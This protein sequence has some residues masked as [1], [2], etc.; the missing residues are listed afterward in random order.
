M[1]DEGASATT[2]PP[3]TLARR[4]GRDGVV[5]VHGAV[6]G[7]ELMTAGTGNDARWRG[8]VA[9]GI[10]VGGAGAVLVGLV[11]AYVRDLGQIPTLASLLGI[12]VLL[13]M[14]A[15]AVRSAVVAS[16]RFRPPADPHT[17]RLTWGLWTFALS[18][19]TGGF[20]W[21]QVAND[22]D[23]GVPTLPLPHVAGGATL[24][25]FGALLIAVTGQRARRA[26]SE[27]AA[28][29]AGTRPQPRLAAIALSA[30]AALLA[31]GS[32]AVAA[33]AV[34]RAPV[35]ATTT[36]ASDASPF[37]GRPEEVL[38]NWRPPGER[39]LISDQIHGT[40]TGVAVG[41]PDRVVALDGATGEEAWSYRRSG[42]SLHALSA[43]LS[44]RSLAAV[45]DSGNHDDSHRRLVTFDAATGRVGTDRVVDRMERPLL[46]DDAVI[47]REDRSLI[48]MSL[49]DGHRMWT[50][51]LPED[52]EFV[53][54]SGEMHATATV[55]VAGGLCGDNW[56]SGAV[57]TV[58]AIDAGT[59]H[60][61][62]RFV[63][64]DDHNTATLET[65]EDGAYALFS[66]GWES[67]PVGNVLIDVATG[68]AVPDVANVAAMPSLMV[69]QG[70]YAA[71][72][73][74]VDGDASTY[75][76][77]GFDGTTRA[78]VE[79]SCAEGQGWDATATVDALVEICR[80]A[81]AAPVTIAVTPWDRPGDAYQFTDPDVVV[82][83]STSLRT[84]PNAV[85][86]VEQSDRTRV[87]A[88]G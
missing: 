9:V 13:V 59:G 60:E 33:H 37:S 35:S 84:A 32:V 75:T 76:L 25:A 30:T 4:W 63:G 82:D 77:T 3:D 43:S 72:M 38:W 62:W 88:L 1:A 65:T 41:L 68:E 42:A 80:P 85:L 8:R 87:I 16:G 52:C 7:M 73:L 29:A 79:S 69:D 24:V 74:T 81:G 53:G 18:A 54:S 71:G 6:I 40:T 46:T 49:D 36:A 26:P 61:E 19:A 34:E 70:L 58:I 56:R 15:W 11:A 66:W 27:S 10:I 86:V 5:A 47:Y 48:A 2:G 22:V 14:L 55:V 67:R 44:G 50:W 78:V 17:E 83:A 45:F 57:A 39:R 20:G 12:A 21:R 28:T 64:G 51:D 23:G 31:A